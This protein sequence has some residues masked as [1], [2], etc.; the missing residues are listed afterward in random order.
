MG[1]LINGKTLG[2]IGLGVI[3][4]ALVKLCNGLN[5]NIKAFDLFHDEEFADRYKVTYCDF[6]T[7]LA[8]S[9][10]LSIHLN[11]SDD[12]YKLINKDQISKIKAGSIL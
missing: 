8:E 3:G 4:K 2:I 5:L 12:T 9:D 1:S 6:D 10:I 11:L 7:L